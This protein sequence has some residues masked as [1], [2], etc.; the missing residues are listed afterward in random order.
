MAGSRIYKLVIICT[1]KMQCYFAYKSLALASFLSFAPRRTPCY[2]F[3]KLFPPNAN[4]VRDDVPDVANDYWE[5]LFFIDILSGR[6]IL[7]V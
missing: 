3:T 1:T 7:G 5:L 4:V 2:F 6:G